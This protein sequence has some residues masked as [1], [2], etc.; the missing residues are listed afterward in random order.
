MRQGHS[1]PSSATFSLIRCARRVWGLRARL[2]GTGHRETRAE[3]FL[4]INKY[5]A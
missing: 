1:S 3:R 5:I 2:P 4:I